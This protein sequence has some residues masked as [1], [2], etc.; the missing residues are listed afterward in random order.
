MYVPS[1]PSRQA[2]L[3]TYVH[4]DAAI[5][6]TRNQILLNIISVPNVF[7]EKMAECTPKMAKCTPT[8]AQCT[9]KITQ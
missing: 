6:F 4:V 3:C 5:E 2:Q 7:A 1:C 9:P 8:I